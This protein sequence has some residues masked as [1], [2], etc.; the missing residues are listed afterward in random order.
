[1]VL[2][3]I[4]CLSLCRGWFS[5]QPAV[6]SYLEVGSLYD[7]PLEDGYLCF[8]VQ[9]VVIYIISCYFLSYV[10]SGPCNFN[11]LFCVPS[12]LSC[13]ENDLCNISILFFATSDLSCVISATCL[14]TGEFYKYSGYFS[15]D[16][17]SINIYYLSLEIINKKTKKTL[18]CHNLIYNPNLKSCYLP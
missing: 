10:A 14:T 9:M 1:V 17:N 5:V 6:F 7:Q 15:F 3:I 8:L 12:D 4:S 18:L 2:C 16:D 13:V 11:I